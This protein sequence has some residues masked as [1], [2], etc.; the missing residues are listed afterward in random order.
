MSRFV[1]KVS[2]RLGSLGTVVP[3]LNSPSPALGEGQEVTFLYFC[4]S[5]SRPK[6]T[7]G[8]PCITD[9]LRNARYPSGHFKNEQW[10]NFKK[11]GKV[12][13]PLKN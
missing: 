4:P 1:K 13:I 2:Y 8:K 10:K 6:H 5:L 9:L 11:L 3:S 12:T 7:V